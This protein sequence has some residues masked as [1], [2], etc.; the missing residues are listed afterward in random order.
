VKELGL[1]PLA[2]IVSFAD[3]EQEPEWFTTAPTVAVPKALKLAGL[4]MNDI[5][6][7]EINEAFAVVTMAFNQ[8]MGVDPAKVNINGGSVALGHP[9]G[10]SGARI[11]TTLFN[12]LMQNNGR[13]GAVGIC[14]GGGGAAALVV[15][16]LMR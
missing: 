7:F 2:R 8:V 14:N 10:A 5:D 6:V 4:G 11:T 16:N 13:Y 9:I 3:A 12:T 1:S 15:E